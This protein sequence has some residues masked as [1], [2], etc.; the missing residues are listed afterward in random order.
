MLRLE[1]S[2]AADHAR[3]VLVLNAAFLASG[4]AP[5]GGPSGSDGRERGS[6]SDGADWRRM[7]VR[8]MRWSAAI[9]LS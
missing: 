5:A 7:A 6:G 1:P 8:D 4:A 3:W 2:S 9:L